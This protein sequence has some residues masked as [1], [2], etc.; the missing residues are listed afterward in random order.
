M[1]QNTEKELKN[2][3]DLKYKTD[4]RNGY[5]DVVDVEKL[6]VESINWIKFGELNFRIKSWIEHFFDITDEDLK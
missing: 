3:K 6:K 4:W 1:K 5:K 2:L